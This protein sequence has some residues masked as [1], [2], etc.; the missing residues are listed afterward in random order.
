MG[1]PNYAMEFKHPWALAH[2]KQKTKD[3]GSLKQPVNV[4]KS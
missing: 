1:F 4:A 3:K 2:E